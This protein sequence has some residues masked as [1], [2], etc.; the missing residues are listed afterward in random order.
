MKKKDIMRR[1][2]RTLAIVVLAGA[3]VLGGCTNAT[4]IGGSAEN[5][6]SGMV[7][8][9]DAGAD[10][11]SSVEYGSGSVK[12][13]LASV[14][15]LD[16]SDMFS[17]KD[18][19]TDY[20]ES[21][22]VVISLNGETATCASD[23]VTVEGGTVIIKAAGNYILQG[24]LKNGSIRI[25]ANEDAKVQL[26]LAGV[27]ITT[28]GTAGIYAKTADKVFITL[29]ENS[30]NTIQNTGAFVAIDDN[31]IDGAIFSKCD[32]TLNAAGSGSETGKL[33]VKSEKGHG[34]VSK[35]DLKVVSGTY[36]ISAGSHG[37][38]GKDSIRI[39]DGNL[40]ITCTNDGLHSGNDEDADKGYVYIENGNVTINAGDDGIHGESKVVIANGTINVSKS[41]E[42]IEAAVIE[43]AGGDVTVNSSDDGLNATKGSSTVNTEAYLIISGGKLAVNAKG[44]GLDANGKIYLKGGETYVS[45]PENN[46]NGA[47]DYDSYAEVTG[48]ILIA[49]GSTGMAMN[50]SNA[51]QGSALLTLSSTHNAGEE[52]K[53]LDSKGNI[54]LNYV[55]S[56]KFASI[57]ITCPDMKQGE[58]YTLTV[59]SETQEFTLDELIYGASNGCGGFGGM[60]GGRRGEMNGEMN[61]NMGG[62]RQGGMNGEMNGNMGGGKKG[63]RGGFGENGGEMPEFPEGFNGERPEFPEGFDGEMPEL[64]EGF[65]GEMPELPENLGSQ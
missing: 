33:I 51:T 56:C 23:D 5:V 25:E 4:S 53:L 44:D 13:A 52:V 19:N 39:A 8:G 14:T 60:G 65:D 41:Y 15:T 7:N 36:E 48:G 63:G 43:V 27:E 38:S 64:P 35:D 62:G 16:V 31:N 58:T 2:S 1:F 24:T 18:Q 17:K 20:E 61:G 12:T 54:L 57:V 28:E 10:T 37:I 11:G 55:P 47:L 30:V 29:A 40:T 42:G 45:G 9:S 46:G 34:I 21:E 50:F 26:I 3:L 22:C 49:A 32:L 59:G 6:A